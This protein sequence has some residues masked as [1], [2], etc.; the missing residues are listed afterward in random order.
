MV[1]G[2]SDL[3]G[4]FDLYGGGLTS[5]L[6]CS[7]GFSS[8]LLDFLQHNANMLKTITLNNI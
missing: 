7:A 8:F 3:D 5:A 4:V 1:W 6:F 2:N